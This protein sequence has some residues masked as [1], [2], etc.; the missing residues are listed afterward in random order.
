MRLIIA[1]S[2][3]ILG[4]AIS[5]LLGYYMGGWGISMFCFSLGMMCYT[6]G[7]RIVMGGKE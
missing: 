2:I 7:L 6:I 1:C 4:L 5:A 3:L